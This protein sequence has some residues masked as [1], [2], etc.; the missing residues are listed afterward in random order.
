MTN[1]DGI[2]SRGLLLLA[3]ALRGLEG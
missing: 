1:D 3:E 2:N